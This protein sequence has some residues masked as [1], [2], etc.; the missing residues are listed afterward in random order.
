MKLGVAFL[1]FTKKSYILQTALIFLA[2]ILGYKFVGTIGTVL[3]A[4]GLLG[5]TI[6]STVGKLLLFLK[7]LAIITFLY[8]VFDDLYTLMKGGQSVIGDTV[9]AL[10][11]LGSGA[12]LG[13]FLN[14]T[15]VDGIRLFKDLAKIL[16]E[17]CWVGQCYRR[18][19]RCFG[20]GSGRRSP[21]SIQGAG[22]DITDGFADIRT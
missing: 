18:R 17:Y 11:G 9:D 21:R 20:K 1:D 8:I 2:G 12:M 10:F 6:A 3:K 19:Y 16:I 15:V 22:K 5:P 7:P 13:L 4:L 14:A